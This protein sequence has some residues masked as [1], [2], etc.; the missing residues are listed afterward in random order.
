MHLL[1]I[2]IDK[3]LSLE[4]KELRSIMNRIKPQNEKTVTVSDIITPIIKTGV[5]IQLNDL[6][7]KLQ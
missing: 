1:K 2:K 5:R 4:I 7:S 6:K 3:E